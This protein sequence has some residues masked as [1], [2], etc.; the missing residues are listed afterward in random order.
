MSSGEQGP[1]EEAWVDPV[2]SRRAFGAL[3]GT[4]DSMIGVYGMLASGDMER[5]VKH[6]ADT[7]FDGD[8]D[9]TNAA[10]RHAFRSMRGTKV[11]G[12]E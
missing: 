5:A 11:L 7:H 12:S 8:C 3:R 2:M 9:I 1:S 6:V 10:I 4:L